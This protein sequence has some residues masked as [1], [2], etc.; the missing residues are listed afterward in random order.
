MANLSLGLD[1]F[2]SQGN[3]RSPMTP[4][5]L[6]LRN[7]I[8]S[9]LGMSPVV[10][11][12][13]TV[14][15]ST[16]AAGT[17]AAGADSNV[18]FNMD[19]TVR[20]LR[21]LTA[22][23]PRESLPPPPPLAVEA[24]VAMLRREI[25][26][27]KRAQ[28][29][30]APSRSAGRTRS[31]RSQATARTADTGRTPVHDRLGPIVEVDADGQAHIL[32]HGRASSRNQQIRDDATERRSRPANS[33]EASSART[34]DVR[35]DE[36]IA[37]ELQRQENRGK[38]PAGGAR[39]RSNGHR[40]SRSRGEGYHQT[41]SGDRVAEHIPS[42]SV[43]RQAPPRAGA[44][45]QRQV[46]TPVTA[47]RNVALNP[48]DAYQIRNE[49]G[50]VVLVNTRTGVAT[51]YYAEGHPRIQPAREDEPRE[52]EVA[53]KKRSS[54]RSNV[55]AEE[56]ELRDR[57]RD[58]P[59]RSR[60]EYRTVDLNRPGPSQSDER[61]EKARR[62]PFVQ[63]ITDTLPP[64]G[65][66]IPKFTK[67]EPTTDAITHMQQYRLIA[68][69]YGYNDAIMC[70]TF[71]MS[72]GS[73][74]LMWYTSLAPNSI[75]EFDELERAFTSRFV[76]SNT[77]P[78]T[79]DALI[80]MKRAADEP[81]KDYITRYWEMYSRVQDCDQRIAASSFKIGLD[82]SSE[83]FREL[84]LRPPRDMAE[85]MA[86][87]DK[88]RELEEVISNRASRAAAGKSSPKEAKK[89]VN[90]LKRVGRDQG[91]GGGGRGYR[92][93]N[94]G[95]NGGRRDRPP[96]NDN[97]Y[98]AETTVF[99]EPIYK[100]LTE[101]G[102]KRWFVWPEDKTGSDPNQKGKCSYHNELGHYT[103]G[104]RPYKAHLERLVAEGRLDEWIDR[105]RTPARG[106]GPVPQ[107]LGVEAAHPQQN[108]NPPRR[109]VVD[110]IHGPIS[111]ARADTMHAELKK[112]E[113]AMQVLSVGQAPKRK[114][115]EPQDPWAITF[116]ERDLEGLELPHDDALVIELSVDDLT[117]RR[118]LV[119]QGS[120]AD[121][122]Y[123]PA[124]KALGRSRDE[125]VPT[126]I[127]L[128][129]FTG[130]PVYPLGTITLPVWAKSVRLDVEFTVVDTHGPY[131]A[132]LGRGWLHGMKAIAS[133]LH[134]CVRFIGANGRQETIW[135][136]QLASKKCFVNAVRVK[137]R[138]E[139]RMPRQVQMIEMP[140]STPVLEDVGLKAEE[141]A[142]EDLVKVPINE[143]G[144][145]YFMVGS[146]LSN[147]EV[148]ELVTFLKDNIEAFAWTP[149]E[150]P[151]VDPS[152]I[153]H[154]LNVDPA[155]KPVVQKPRRSSAIHSDAVT[156]EVQRLIE[157]DAIREV[158]YPTWLANTVVVKKKNGKW[159]VCVDYTNLNDACPKD[160]FPLP[161]IDQLVDATAG[162]ARLS[163]M[164]AY[165]GYHQIAMDPLD[166]EKTAFISP[167]GT[168]CY[169]VMPFGLKNAGA[170]Y[171]RMVSKM[172]EQQLGDI[173]EAYIDDMVVKSKLAEDHLSHLG[174]IFTILKR[175]KLKLNAEKCAFGVGSGKFLGYL[176]TRRG[177]E[178]DPNQ[179][180]AIQNLRAPTTI[181]EVQRL[182][183]MAAALNRFIS[184]SSDVCRPFF[185]SIK[186]SKRSFQWTAECDA[187]LAELKEYMSRA[188]L[189]VTPKENEDLYLYLAVSEH[190]VSSALVRKDG[191]EQYP[192]YYS[193]KTMLPAETRYRPIEKLALA[194]LTAKR[195]L[196]PY[197]ECHTIIVITEYPLKAVLKNANLSDRICRWSLE[198]ANFDVR[199]EPRT[200]IKGQALADFIAELTPRLEGEIREMP[201]SEGTEEPT[202]N[203][204]PPKQP[205]PI[206]KRSPP[207]KAVIYTGDKW[208]LH[209][210]GASN[211]RGAGAGIVLISPEGTLHECAMSIGFPATNNEAE[212]EALIAGLKLAKGLG[213]EELEVYSDS[214]LV[215]NQLNSEYGSGEARMLQY[216]GQ[217]QQLQAAF[218]TVEFRHIGRANN[219]H[220]DALAA[221]GSACFEAGGSR[222]VIL[223]D[224][225]SPSFE[226]RE[227]VVLCVSPGPSWMDPV[228]AYLRDEQLPSDKKEAHRIRCQSASYF[229]SASGQ[230]YRRSY[231]GPDL[232]VLHEQEIPQVLHELHEGSCGCH[233][234]GR[235]LAERAI[236]QGYWWPKMRKS[237]ED[238]VK[239]CDACQ[240]HATILHQPTLSLQPVTSPW[241]F[242]QWGLDIVGV[243]PTAPG[244][245][246]HLITATDY[247]TK[248]V[249]AEPLVHIT[250][251]EVEQF[252]W[253]N[254]I[255]RFGVP[256]A[257]ISDNGT[258]FVAEGV[259]ALCKKKNIRV[260]NST[261]A[262]P[263]GNG[264]AEASN[265]SISAGIKRRLTNKRG[266][267][268][269]EL[270][271]VLWG[272]RTTP[273]RGTGRTPFSMAYGME[274]V[275]PTAATAPTDRTEAFH[276][277][278]NEEHVA[279][280]LNHIEDLRDEAN[281]KYAAYQQDVARNYNK[282]VRIRPF[283]VDD[284]VLR[285]VVQKKNKKKFM[286]NW[287][288]PFRITAKA[289]YGAY[290]LAEMDG[291][292]VS[293]PWNASKL[294]KFYG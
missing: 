72:L 196:L 163:F 38:G 94:R 31:R 21:S 293:N 52:R 237:A 270:P 171:Q 218:K 28:A 17:S 266:K 83:L 278:T 118:I 269:E 75:S 134:Q 291:T 202:P 132:I 27:L 260:F 233:S 199:F 155:R 165:R 35:H 58:P 191:L 193:S 77:Q 284:L 157:A 26:A 263:Q 257:I 1:A 63:E 238:Y 200:S 154:S 117:V 227:E 137:D 245:F 103:T 6:N 150:M 205:N 10:N 264:Q 127:P 244:G 60:V 41:R 93:N 282:H 13:G 220:A 277:A 187:A 101:I 289:G 126:D 49:E 216:I 164:D 195:K 213:I 148:N 252:I 88:Y 90:N 160:C 280:E 242:A 25:D 204:A 14:T 12:D 19:G 62:S 48:G 210:D 89:Q 112:V 73:V 128:V 33:A 138:K 50:R 197:F 144:S 246:K 228:V 169:K 39:S 42:R 294:R 92:D 113:A 121:V 102:R 292:P 136:D 224:I 236:T 287:E 221:L 80:N 142:I 5:T 234:G 152:F 46:P 34:P 44:S 185:Q 79:I 183:G 281:I 286:P 272:Y 82:D 186:T 30:P 9:D 146:E 170:T 4:H 99:T 11:R 262:Y 206:K 105:N 15:V 254:I 268:V 108:Q 198:L 175:H 124:F 71:S 273:R 110:V 61:L 188:P 243:L 241:P 57:V 116:T 125:L 215:I 74:A 8:R 288:G 151:G 16:N 69:L 219:A 159:R 64:P 153:T 211:C 156:E 255:S 76:T 56:I 96:R 256:Y 87:A 107:A 70:K 192:V 3:F 253:K 100:L 189:L 85:L 95:N 214:M 161:R 222:T 122:L 212:Y 283:Q 166:E 274:A 55:Q 111:K 43:D 240:K 248:W 239:K 162:H 66:R 168:Y 119:D 223:G 131:N 37:R 232:R 2:D 217:V 184:R 265:K 104:C 276:P 114:F 22:T 135:G 59:K 194:L 81:L 180:T 86:T 247:F 149:Y 177:I 178:A 23:I 97:D 167:R 173:M 258:Q 24:E 207:R 182:T 158:Q 78:K 174:K 226:Q 143:D 230:L 130:N 203:N 225:P 65:Y 201:P 109:G 123:Y 249:E 275:L 40:A 139:S 84:T 145:R 45:G 229:L 36:A 47:R 68:D 261:V 259:K 106:R 208:R 181:K 190:A 20:S 51:A 18:L 231:T 271:K 115:Q 250:A 91:S 7:Q 285:E 129:G 251:T 172:F 98:V 267:W 67:Y 147:P 279:A 179:L 133:T 290:K 53:T 140:E 29:A 176:V 120:S 235:S 32:Q 54:E 141:K 209:V